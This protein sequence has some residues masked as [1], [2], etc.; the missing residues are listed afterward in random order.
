M[1]ARIIAYLIYILLLLLFNQ[2]N[3][4]LFELRVEKVKTVNDLR[5]LLHYVGSSGKRLS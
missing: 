2:I 5:S 1:T 4:I 3:E